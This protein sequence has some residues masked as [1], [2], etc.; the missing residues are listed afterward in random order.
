MRFGMIRASRN[1]SLHPRRSKL[2]RS[3][4]HQRE[5]GKNLDLEPVTTSS[6]R[7]CHQSQRD[8]MANVS[9][10]RGGGVGGGP[11]GGGG[12]GGGCCVSGLGSEFC[13]IHEI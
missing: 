13:L 1:S 3:V 9:H 4:A 10:Q 2:L 11:G 6:I 12:G 7:E 5:T 8:L